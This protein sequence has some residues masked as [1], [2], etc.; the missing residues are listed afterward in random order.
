MN[1]KRLAMVFA[2]V[3]LLCGLLLVACQAVD[4]P[5]AEPKITAGAPQPEMSMTQRHHL[6]DRLWENQAVGLTSS[7]LLPA[8]VDVAGRI[9]FQDQRDQPL[10]SA[11]DSAPERGMSMTDRHH[12]HDRLWDGQSASTGE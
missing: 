4:D 1:K 5:V 11:W 9:Q 7:S 3:I 8:S 10:S 6:H 12:L 2:M